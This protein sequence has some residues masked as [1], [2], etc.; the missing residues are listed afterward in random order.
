MEAPR[1]GPPLRPVTANV[2]GPLGWMHCTFHVPPMQSLVD[3]LGPGIQIVKCTRVRIALERETMPFLALRRESISVVEPTLGDELVESPGSVG[4]TTNRD[5]ACLLPEGKLRG[6]LEVL[7]NVRV[8]DFLRQQASLIVMRRCL[9]IPYGQ[10][11]ES[12]QARKVPIAVVNMSRAIG[13]SEWET[14]A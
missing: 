13:V 12:S 6:E 1:K 8:S 5:V 2:L 10:S 14:T 11:A 7:V 9:L 4:N 3:F